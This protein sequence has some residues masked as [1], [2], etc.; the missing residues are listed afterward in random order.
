MGVSYVFADAAIID[1]DEVNTN[2]ADVMDQLSN[3]TAADIS[4]S[5]GIVSTQLADRY[6]IVTE[7]ITLTSF[8]QDHHATVATEANNWFPNANT[9]G[10]EV[11]RKYFTLRPGRSQHLCAISAY[12]QSIVADGTNRPAVFVTRNGTVV[13]GG[14]S[15]A[16]ADT[17]YHLRNSNPIDTPLSSLANDDYL[18]IG[19]GVL[20]ADGSA[21]S[22]AICRAAGVT[23]TLTYKM[24]LTS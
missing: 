6:A 8:Y 11:W 1:P 14:I 4:T 18:T 15:L 12:A 19:L 10:T 2:F 23:L 9:P 13:S 5:A 24:E 7:T 22:S 21:G 17:V 3:I 20:N 16:T